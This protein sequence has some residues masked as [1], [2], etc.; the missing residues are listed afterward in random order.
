MLKIHKFTFNQFAENTYVAWCDETKDAAVI[1]PGCFDKTEQRQL[2]NFIDEN[3]L[4]VKYLLNTHCHIDHVLG[5]KFVI[6]RFNPEYYVPEKDMILLQ[7]FAKQCEAV[8]MEAEQPP[9]PEKYITEELNIKIGNVPIKFLFTPGHTAGEYCFYFETEKKCIT[10]DVLFQNSIGRTDLF[11]GDF[12]TLIGSIGTKLLTLDDEVII[13]PG[14][15]SESTIGNERN[16]NP[17]L[18]NVL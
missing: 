7:H 4:K 5:N 12:Q 11:G 15:G 10:G 2:E 6:D 14:H 16:E 9:L 17:F 18:Q 1:D 13:Y 8:G 3:L